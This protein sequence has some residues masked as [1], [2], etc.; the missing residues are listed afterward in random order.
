M[1]SNKL[2]KALEQFNDQRENNHSRIEVLNAYEQGNIRGGNL[3]CTCKK[4]QTVI[5]QTSYSQG[6]N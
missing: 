3:G 6:T 1:K 5:C 4:N 2:K